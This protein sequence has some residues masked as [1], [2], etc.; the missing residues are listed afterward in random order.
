MLTLSARAYM[1]RQGEAAIP[2][3]PYGRI[4]I[5]IAPD[6]VVSAVEPGVEQAKAPGSE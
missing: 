3:S 6:K 5:T 4:R 1:E 2:P